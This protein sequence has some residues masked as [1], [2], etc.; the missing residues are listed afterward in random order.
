MTKQHSEPTEI[1]A[2]LIHG[3]NGDGPFSLMRLA[4]IFTPSPKHPDRVNS[5]ENSHL[6]FKLSYSGASL[7][8]YT[9]T[10]AAF[11]NTSGGYLVF[12]ISPIPP[13][14]WRG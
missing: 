7:G 9:K 10:I 5:R 13:I 1:L 3:A 12:G 6:E 2:S 8:K 14:E 11:A 4:A